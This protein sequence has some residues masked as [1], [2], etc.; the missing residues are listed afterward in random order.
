MR[1]KDKVVIVTGAG[2]GIRLATA[3]CFAQDGA[4]VIV[5]ERD[6]AKGSDAARAIRDA[7]GDAVAVLCDV[8][9]EAD[10]ARVV[11]AAFTRHGRL[12]V[13]VN[14]AGRM[15]FKPIATRSRPARRTRST[16]ATTRSS[17]TAAS[18]ARSSRLPAR[19]PRR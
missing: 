13:I 14:N 8:A 18:R 12:D 11:D 17:A 9:V 16:R 3:R 7:G 4:H 1:F 5:A 15:I 10:V 19:S 6:A 2:S